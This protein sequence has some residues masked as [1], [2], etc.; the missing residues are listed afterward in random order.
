MLFSVT[1]NAFSR[2]TINPH[3]RPH[4][5]IKWKRVWFHFLF[6]FIALRSYSFFWIKLKFGEYAVQTVCKVLKQENIKPTICTPQQNIFQMPKLVTLNISSLT[7]LTTHSI[8]IVLRNQSLYS[9]GNSHAR[10]RCR[11]LQ[12]ADQ[13]LTQPKNTFK[14]LLTA[15]RSIGITCTLLLA[16]FR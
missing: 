13:L 3:D 14:H 2:A 4:A 6:V 9:H 7:L 16:T 11:L 8:K 1:F 5:H 10:S 15:M 12:R